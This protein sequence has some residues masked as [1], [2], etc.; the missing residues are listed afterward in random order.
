[1][2]LA[3]HWPLEGGGSPQDG[4]R[5]GAALFA[6]FWSGFL[7]EGSDCLA[8]L[9]K[10]DRGLPPSTARA[11]ALATASKLAAHYGDDATATTLAEE[12]LTLP[13]FWTPIANA[14]VHN[15]LGLVALHAGDP[16]RARVHVMTALAEG[17]RGGDTQGL[18]LYLFYLGGLE[19]ADSHPQQ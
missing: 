18:A 5:L 13:G 16:A 11:W 14:F 3:W 4:L 7:N 1:L 10:R 19:V 6:F 17:E 8:A 15:A 2:R 9:L 12:Y